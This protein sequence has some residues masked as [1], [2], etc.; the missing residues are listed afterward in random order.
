MDTIQIIRLR[1]AMDTLLP[2]RVFE[3]G[4]ELC[5]LRP[6]KKALIKIRSGSHCFLFRCFGQKKQVSFTIP[7]SGSLYTIYCLR[8]LLQIKVQFGKEGNNIH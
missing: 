2:I 7:E 1:S 8:S 4:V 3:D 5:R 6:G